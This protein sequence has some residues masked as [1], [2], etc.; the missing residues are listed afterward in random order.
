MARIMEKMNALQKEV[1]ELTAPPKPKWIDV[2]IDKFLDVVPMHA[3]H[4]IPLDAIKFTKIHSFA[5]ERL[6]FS[7]AKILISPD[8][9]KKI[10][11]CLS[12]RLDPMN[13][14][15]YRQ[16]EI[17]RDTVRD[18]LVRLATDTD[19]MLAGV[20]PERYLFVTSSVSFKSILTLCVKVVGGPMV[21][22]DMLCS[23]WRM[24][25]LYAENI[26]KMWIEGAKRI[27]LLK[28]E[29][30]AVTR[31]FRMDKAVDF[32]IEKI[33]KDILPKV[34]FCMP[35]RRDLYFTSQ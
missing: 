33:L 7:M 3:E 20:I 14:I 1:Q 9:R 4:G 2:K 8:H 28:P 17:T 35:T 13:N 22:E 15:P 30:M 24:I 18:I 34:P 16:T 21:K 23:H 19:L 6:G 11:E 10:F 29:D 25:N 32:F 31:C 27:C 26:C 12:V 5:L